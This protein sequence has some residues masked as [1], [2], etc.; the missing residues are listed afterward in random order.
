[1]TA[2]RDDIE[3]FIERWSPSGGGERSNCQMFLTELCAL[4]GVAPPDPAVEADSENAYV[5]ER[6]IPARRL[7][8]PTTPNFIDLY[9]R[10]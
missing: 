6:K 5:F 8:G 1:M 7:D 9:K 4:I 10:G 2:G 3:A